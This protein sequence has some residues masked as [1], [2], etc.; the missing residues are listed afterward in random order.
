MELWQDK[1][2]VLEEFQQLA[3]YSEFEWAY[4]NYVY[5]VYAKVPEG[6]ERLKELA[7]SMEKLGGGHYQK[8]ELKQEY[9]LKQ[10]RQIQNYL[11]WNTIYSLT[12]GVKP[13]E[14]DFAEYFLFDNQKGYCAHYATSAV[15]LLRCMNI[16]ARYVE[17]YIVTK[18]DIENG[19]SGGE[20]IVE[21]NII[22]KKDNIINFEES[23]QMTTVEVKDLNAHAWIEVYFNGFGWIPFE[24]TAGYSSNID[25]LLPEINEAIKENVILQNY[26]PIL[27]HQ[28]QLQH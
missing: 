17:G 20:G 28:V 24:V 9:I 25:A 5:E 19:I 14:K 11:E 1:T 7:K 22:I 16:P 3:D 6:L 15:L 26:L 21:H 13:K 10:I 4:R 8:L 2:F 18:Q 27:Q 12:P 23:E